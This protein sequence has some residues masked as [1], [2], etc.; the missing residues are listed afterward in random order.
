MSEEELDDRFASEV[1][2]LWVDYFGDVAA[3][4]SA[5]Q[6]KGLANILHLVLAGE[7]AEE[8]GDSALDAREAYDRVSAFLNRQPSLGGV[9]GSRDEFELKYITVP[10]IKSIVNEIDTIEK[11]IDKATASRQRLKELLESMYTGNK[12]IVFSE[13]EISVEVGISGKLR[14]PALSSGEKQLFF[15]CL[16]TLRANGNSL[17]IDEPELSMHVDWQKKLVA[18]LRELNPEMQLIMATHSPEITA[19]LSDEKIFRM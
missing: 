18:S 4:V 17:I 14:L 6:E 2:R 10:Q 8:V 19:D 16:A 13:K 12:R 15:I 11:Q 7:E 3:T 9:L 5:V 1:Q